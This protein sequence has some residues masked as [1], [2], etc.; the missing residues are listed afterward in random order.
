MMM[1]TP[2]LARARAVARPIPLVEPV[3]NAVLVGVVILMYRTINRP[4]WT[5]KWPMSQGN[6][7]TRGVERVVNEVVLNINILCKPLSGDWL[8]IYCFV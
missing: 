1:L 7:Q 4:R 2:R 8:N 5:V 6:C 3:T